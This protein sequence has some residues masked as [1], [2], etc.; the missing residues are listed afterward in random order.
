MQRRP[1]WD[2]EVVGLGNNANRNQEQ[3]E[4][5]RDPE[6]NPFLVSDSELAA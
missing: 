1:S 5:D 4:R 3:T 6:V 2:E